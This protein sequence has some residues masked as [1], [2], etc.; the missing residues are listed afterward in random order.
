M[1]V[2]D[3]DENIS[4]SLTFFRAHVSDASLHTPNEFESCFFFVQIKA[5]VMR[6]PSCLLFHIAILLPRE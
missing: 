6:H 1:L 3:D 4:V 5:A 2:V